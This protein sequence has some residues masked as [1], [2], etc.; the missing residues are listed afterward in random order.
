M[1]RQNQRIEEY[2]SISEGAEQKWYDH[3]NL[4]KKA[5]GCLCV[6]KAGKMKKKKKTD[7]TQE[8]GKSRKSIFIFRAFILHDNC[9]SKEKP[10]KDSSRSPAPKSSLVEKYHIQLHARVM[11]AVHSVINSY[12]TPT[13]VAKLMFIS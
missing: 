2:E 7:S 11:V 10:P 13:S 12:A 5:S 9:C 4:R 6:E 8:R 3:V 1:G